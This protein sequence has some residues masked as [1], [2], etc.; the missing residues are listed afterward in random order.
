MDMAA[1]RPPT[2]GG[3]PVGASAL[4][5]GRA[6]EGSVHLGPRVVAA[7]RS[8]GGS[9]VRGVGVEP[10]L[11]LEHRTVWARLLAQVPPLHALTSAR[12]AARQVLP[13]SATCLTPVAC[14]HSVSRL[15]ATVASR[16][17]L[18]PLSRPPRPGPC[19]GT[20]LAVQ[21]GLLLTWAPH[22][23]APTLPAHLLNPGGFQ[24]LQTQQ[25]AR[26]TGASRWGGSM[27][28]RLLAV[29]PSTAPSTAGRPPLEGPALHPGVCSAAPGLSWVGLVASFLQL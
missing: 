8:V 15:L 16:R 11:S 9:Q 20:S 25:E 29:A 3:R 23:P 4:E 19:G 14:R 28:T 10:P 22:T 2:W 6:P 24:K 21:A 13:P 1:S 17:A 7:G 12:A 27:E 5:R 26:E 18:G